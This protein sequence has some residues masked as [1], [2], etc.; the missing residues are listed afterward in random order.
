MVHRPKA[1][2]TLA[3]FETG[4]TPRVESTR[5]LFVI[6]KPT[7]AQSWK[8]IFAIEGTSRRRSI[9]PIELCGLVPSKHSTLKVVPLRLSSGHIGAEYL[10][11][12]PATTAAF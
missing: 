2:G 1:S 10:D 4:F 12:K 5:R 3:I 8:R 11:D 6:A 9:P 7:T